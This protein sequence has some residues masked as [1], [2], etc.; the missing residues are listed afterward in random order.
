MEAGPLIHSWSWQVLVVY[1]ICCFVGGGQDRGVRWKCTG[2]CSSRSSGL[3]DSPESF[4]HPYGQLNVTW[5]SCSAGASPQSSLQLIMMILRNKLIKHIW[6]YAILQMVWVFLIFLCIKN[7][8]TH[9][10]KS[11]KSQIILCRWP[12]PSSVRFSL[13]RVRVR[14]S[15]GKESV[16]WCVY[17]YAMVDIQRSNSVLTVMLE[18]EQGCFWDGCC[19]Y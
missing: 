4:P 8:L 1:F 17:F 7:L 2:L 15:Q 19:T 18:K 10:L 5:S 3:L 11:S 14:V 12:H 16:M 9:P 13:V 6:K